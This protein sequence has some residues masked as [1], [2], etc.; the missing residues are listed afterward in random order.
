VIT[1]FGVIEYE[2][3]NTIIARESVKK[4]EAEIKPKAKKLSQKIKLQNATEALEDENF[5]EEKDIQLPVNE[6]SKAKPK[7]KYSKKKK[8]LI[9]FEIEE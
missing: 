3:V 8:E 2:Q 7:R 4:A 9:E 6:A 5:E 1:F